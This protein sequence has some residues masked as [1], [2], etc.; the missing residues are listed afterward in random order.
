MSTKLHIHKVT[1]DERQKAK[2][3][4]NGIRGKSISKIAFSQMF[5]AYYRDQVRALYRAVWDK[6]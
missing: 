3:T 2:K 4:E 1:L 5:D 6:R